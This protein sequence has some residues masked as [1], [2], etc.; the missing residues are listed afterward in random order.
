MTKNSM[1]PVPYPPYSPNLTPSDSFIVSLDEI[2]PQR[3]TFCHVGKGETKNSRCYSH[4]S[5]LAGLNLSNPELIAF[6]REKI[7]SALCACS[8]LI[9]LTRACMSHTPPLKRKCFSTHHLLSTHQFQ[10]SSRVLERIKDEY[11]DTTVKGIKIHKFKHCFEQWKK[12]L[13]GC[14][15]SHGEYFEGD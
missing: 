14:I 11:R 8:G 3:E 6:S 1:A 10:H 5:V 4:I 9:A 13:N 12:H 15:A 7:V 2:S